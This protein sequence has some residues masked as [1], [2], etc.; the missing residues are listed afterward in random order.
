VEVSCVVDVSEKHTVSDI[1][2]EVR[3]AVKVDSLYSIGIDGL[4]GWMETDWLI[5]SME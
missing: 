1:S 3:S 5:R 4:D 2:V